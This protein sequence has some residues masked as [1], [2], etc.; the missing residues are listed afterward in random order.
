M[1]CAHCCGGARAVWMVRIA[2][3]AMTSWVM[4]GCTSHLAHLAGSRGH[5]E[6]I[7]G[8][9]GPTVEVPSVF[10]LS[11]RTWG[12][13]HV[14]SLRTSVSTECST[15]P[16]LPASIGPGKSIEVAVIAKFRPQAGDSVCTVQLETAGEPPLVLTIDGRFQPSSPVDAG[17]PEP[18]VPV[19]QSVPAAPIAPVAPSVK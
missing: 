18:I 19:T 4:A 2:A 8:A 17:A 3:V 15:V 16:P 12:T 1:S 14:G 9:G 10:V 11:N 7:T 13:V 6:W 5:T